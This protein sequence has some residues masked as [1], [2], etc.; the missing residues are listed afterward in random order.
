MKN[1]QGFSLIELAIV[2]VIVTLLIGGLAVPLSAQ[3]QAR[4]IAEIRADMD[5]IKDA[6][7]GYAMSH[8]FTHTSGAVRH[9]LP[10]P[11]TGAGMPGVETPRNPLTGQCASV[12]GTLPW[13]TLGV[14]GYDALGNRYTYAVTPAFSN[15]QE[16]FVSTPSAT[17][18]TLNVFPDASCGS[19]SVA[20]G[21]PAVVV[22]HGPNGRGA[23]NINGGTP[24]AAT[25][26]SAAERHN[27]IASTPTAPCDN[28]SFIS[29]TPS[30]TFD[31][32]VIWLSAAALFNRVCPAGG[33]L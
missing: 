27:L 23:T 16:G 25:D 29:A 22:S 20:A 26:L 13:R 17:P 12:R 15:N 10:C 11:D 19:P 9:Y 1:Q 5:V 30:D 7:I 6:L 3:I 31:D 21:V 32:L 28:N 24:L 33:C 14:K 4:R 18:G 2:L 8:T